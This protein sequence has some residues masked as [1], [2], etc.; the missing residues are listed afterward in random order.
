MNF[1]TGITFDDVLLV[2]KRSSVSSRRHI[3]VQTKLTR[4]ISLNNP[5]VSSNMDTVTETQMAIA[6][7]RNGGIGIIHRFL[8][9]EEQVRMVEAVKRAESY[10]IEDPWTL[11][12]NETV[13]Q[14]KEIM[15]EKGVGSLLVTELEDAADLQKQRL[16][17]IITTRDVRFANDDEL[18]SEYMTPRDKLTVSNHGLTLDDAK[19]VLNHNRIEK[20]PLVDESGIYLR[21]L[22]TSKDIIKASH[23]PH[24]SLDARGSLLVGAAVGVK[25]ED[26]ERAELLVAAGCD[27]I[28]IDIAHGHSDLALNALRLLKQRLPHTD[29]IAGNVCTAEGARDLIEAGA[30]AIKVGVGPGSICTTRIVSGCGVPQLT[31]VLDCAAEAKKH[32]IPLIADGGIRTSGDIV[33]ALAAGASTIMLGSMLA[34][35]DESPG[36]TLVKDGKKVKVVRGMAGY[37]A[38]ISKGQRIHGKDDV[39]DLV[40]EGVEAMVPY[41]GA[42]VGIISQLVG[43]LCSGISY[44]GGHNIEEMREKAEFIRITGAGKQ[45]SGSHDVTQL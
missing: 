9:V 7:A 10:K 26:I 14:L 22:I 32:G 41:R 43:G 17:G 29:I 40:P 16:L 42:L 25:W 33:K 36:K 21:G 20:L 5:I 27:V 19:N 11:R 38:N 31:A 30:D 24:A 34:G 3:S 18:V 35:T 28:V 39:F 23:R 15:Y 2:P 44:C 13:R 8:S 45:E 4:N 12:P 37:G 6:M 1:R